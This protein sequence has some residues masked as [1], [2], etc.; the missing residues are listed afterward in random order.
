MFY[1]SSK[2]NNNDIKHGFYGYLTQ[3]RHRLY[4]LLITYIFPNI[5][6]TENVLTFSVSYIFAIYHMPL[7]TK[8]KK[9][10]FSLV[11]KGTNY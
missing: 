2:E 7:I 6:D 3:T 11:I 4:R 10:F 1:K 9:L 5:Y 8:L